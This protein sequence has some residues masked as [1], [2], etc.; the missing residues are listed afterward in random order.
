[1]KEEEQ[2]NLERLYAVTLFLK[3]YRINSGYTQEELSH[4]SGIHRNTIIRYESCNPENLTLLTLFKI[5]DAF[6]GLNIK[7]IFLDIV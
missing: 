5:C 2:H 3:W 7:Q 6:E 1:M 4:Y